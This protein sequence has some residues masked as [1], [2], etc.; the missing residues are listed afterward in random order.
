M[1]RQRPLLVALAGGGLIAI[2][3]LVA[4]LSKRDASP[5]EATAPS[6]AT[7]AQGSATTAVATGS[8]GPVVLAAPAVPVEQL[9][10]S[11]DEPAAPQASAKPVDSALR[12]SAPHVGRPPQP[13][14]A[15][16]C[17]PPYTVDAAGKKKWKRECL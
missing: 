15:A 8:E 11:P 9:P 1:L 5:V 3:V 6:S 4:A 12:Q 7:H 10:A 17:S 2:V 14:A 13:A 16:G